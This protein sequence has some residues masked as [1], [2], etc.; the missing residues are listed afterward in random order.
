[1]LAVM[2]TRVLGML[3]EYSATE[4]LVVQ[5]K[6]RWYQPQIARKRSI[7]KGGHQVAQA[8]LRFLVGRCRILWMGAGQSS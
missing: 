1:V 2:A 7:S 3:F 6:G 4:N 8:V 5:S